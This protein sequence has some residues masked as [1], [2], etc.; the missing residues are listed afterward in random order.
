MS[1]FLTLSMKFTKILIV[2]LSLSTFTRCGSSDPEPDQTVTVLSATIDGASIN[3]NENV[4]ID[5]EI[6]IVFSA[7][8]D[9]TSFETE[10]SISD[11]STSKN[12]VVAYSNG[13][14]K[15]TIS[16]EL[17][18]NTSYSL[19]VGTGIIGRNG[20]RFST[21]LNY[22]FT[23]S[24]DGIIRSMSPCTSTGSCL[25][26]V[27]LQGSLG[28]GIFEFYS[29][30]PIYEENAQWKSL[31]QAVFVVHGASHNPDDYYSYLT[32]TLEGESLSEKTILIAPFF[33]SSTTGSS[34]DFYWASTNWR[35]GQQSSNSNKISSFTVIDE[36]I[37]QLSNKDLFPVLKKIIITGH[38]SGAAF[39]HVFGGANISETA[40]SDVEFK[41]VVANSQFLYYPDDQRIDEANN[42]LYTPTNCSAYNIWPLGFISK[43][44]YLSNTDVSTFN[45]NFKDR[46][47][48]YLLGNGNQSDPTLNTTSCQ[49]ILQGSSRYRRGENMLKFME[50]IYPSLH[51]HTKTIVNGIG[52]NGSGMYQ[53][54]EFRTLLNNLLN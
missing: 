31:T 14:T 33:R 48:I 40:H 36:L 51:N 44:P 46:S 28:L 10:L 3:T 22:D 24:A 26:N 52:H 1:L 47:I 4:S 17:E 53:S 27:K 23:T 43:P 12:F 39:T 2:I 21:V 11:G 49:N 54:T 15:A 29:N 30:Y 50:L 7:T 41:Y 45:S 8:L 32:N 34:E 6:V 19:K 5:A 25:R 35:R 9:Q 13:N 16:S 42:Q 38:S 37:N 18:Y 20:E